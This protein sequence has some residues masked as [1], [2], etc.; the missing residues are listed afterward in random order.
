MDFSASNS[1][2]YGSFRLKSP[3][4]WTIDRKDP[5]SW[6]FRWTRGGKCS[7]PSTVSRQRVGLDENK[8]GP[9][10]PNQTAV[11]SLSSGD[12]DLREIDALFFELFYN[13]L[14]DAL[15]VTKLRA[16]KLTKEYGVGVLVVALQG[17][18]AA[19]DVVA[20]GRNVPFFGAP[21]ETPKHIW[22]P[23]LERQEY[24]SSR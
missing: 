19:V 9:R 23:Q 18:G 22:I 24:Q 7:P 16:P 14:L 13:P 12:C 8:T 21:K 5:K 15:G 2:T 10:P 1:Q 11:R 20:D 4:S 6:R 3:K 17:R